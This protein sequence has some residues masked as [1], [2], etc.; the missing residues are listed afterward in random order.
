MSQSKFTLRLAA[1]SATLIAA[2]YV[3][4]QEAVQAGADAAAN[5]AGQVQTEVEAANQE[6]QAEATATADAAADATVSGPN[7]APIVD[8]AE[9]RVERTTG[10]AEGQVERTTERVE[11]VSNGARRAA[12]AAEHRAEVLLRGPVHEAFA[13]PQIGEIVRGEIA[14]QQPPAAVKEIAPAAEVG[15]QWIE[16]YW[17]FDESAGDFV[18][19]TGTLRRAP[20][21]TVWVA[22]QWQQTAEGYVRTPGYW[23]VA[24]DAQASVDAQANAAAET[25]AAIDVPAHKV[26]TLEGVIDVPGYVDHPLPERGVLYAPMRI[27]DS[28][29]RRADAIRG[30]AT[31]V[32]EN[33]ASAAAAAVDDRQ[34][35]VNDRV[36]N[37]RD[38][39]NAT[40]DA[41]VD[42]AD[43]RLDQASDRVDNVRDRVQNR[44]ENVKDAA[45]GRVDNAVDRAANAQDQVEN[46]AENATERTEMRLENAEERVA[47]ARENVE[48]AAQAKVDAA[49]DDVRELKT[50]GRE[51]VAD[52]QNAAQANVRET[53]ETVENVDAQV[54]AAGEVAAEAQA[55]VAASS[56]ELAAD[57]SSSAVTMVDGAL[58][59]QPTERISTDSLMLHLFADQA[60]DAFYFGDYYGD[61]G[62]ALNLVHWSQTPVEPGSLLAEHDELYGNQNGSFVERLAGWEKYFEANALQRPAHTL[63]AATNRLQDASAAKLHRLSHLSHSVSA[64]ATG[65]SQRASDVADRATNVDPSAN[66]D[67]NLSGDVSA[68]VSSN[69]ASADTLQSL[70]ADVQAG[71]VTGS[72]Q[73]A[74]GL[75]GSSQNGV[76]APNVRVPLNS[77]RLPRANVSG[78]NGALNGGLNGA[79]GISGPG[80][81][82]VGG[83]LGGAVGGA[84]GK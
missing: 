45:N 68:E 23:N 56:N 76:G 9:G 50:D 82:N 46:R 19:V 77:P 13:R 74:A 58:T 11:N 33:R 31:N 80:L 34:D 51:A 28:T 64:K 71:R 65:V 39:A 37:V 73:S 36:Q 30:R 83:G 53:R 75:N 49:A 81:G 10:R 44:A 78:P 54:D 41:A 17:S 70:N 57:A 2:P 4:G 24:S 69:G 60:S 48:G 35:A 8:R 43:A 26:E 32:V 3:V 29:E 59:V 84:L 72:V 52:V 7:P 55:S 15:T 62:Q 16:G 1:A 47:N 61:A 66:V 20:E 22:G 12:T 27:V 14:P 5:A 18:W 25:A 63:D 38:R 6:V 40:A 42:R 79:G 67:A 21:G